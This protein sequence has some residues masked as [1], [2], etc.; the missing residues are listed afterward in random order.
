MRSRLWPFVQ[1]VLLVAAAALV[2]AC[3]SDPRPAQPTVTA[4]LPL[5][6]ASNVSVIPNII[7]QFDRALDSTTATNINNYLLRVKGSASSLGI[8]VDFLSA[9]NEVRIIPTA[10]L[11]LNTDYEVFVSGLVKSAEGGELGVNVGFGFKTGTPS[12]ISQIAFSTPSAVAGANP[13]EIVLTWTK[14]TQTPGPVDVPNYDIYASKVQGG[15]DFMLP[16]TATSASL[17]GQTI[18]T[19]QGL[20]ANTQYWIKVQP[21]DSFGGVLQNLTEIGPIT[22]AP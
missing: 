11:S 4:T 18:G 10:M 2:P 20:E 8:T 15:Q 12:S 14:A 13:G 17:T 6:G 19:A 1:V 9:V 16:A 5:N 21:R 7:F 3:N 22:S